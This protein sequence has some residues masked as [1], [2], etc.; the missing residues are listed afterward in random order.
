MHLINKLRS[1][2]YSTLYLIV[3]LAAIMLEHELAKNLFHTLLLVLF[4]LPFLN[5]SKAFTRPIKIYAGL[6][7]LFI[8]TTQLS[9]TL[10]PFSS[11]TVVPNS[12]LQWVLILPCAYLAYQ[13]K[14]N[15]K[16]L[17]KILAAIMIAT[18]IPAVH[19]VYYQSFRYDGMHSQP[20]MWGNLAILTG[21][22]AFYLALRAP[23]KHLW[24]YGLLLFLLGLIISAISQSRGGWISVFTLS[25]LILLELY[26]KLPK[27]FFISAAII[28]I[29]CICGALTSPKLGLGQRFMMGFEN[30]IKYSQGIK[31]AE[32]S[33]IGQRFEFWKSAIRASQEHP[34]F[35]IGPS[36]FK[37]WIRQDP[38]YRGDIRFNHAHSQYF[39]LLTFGIPSA[40]SFILMIAYFYWLTGINNKH[41]TT[42]K[43]CSLIMVVA[44]LEFSLTE[45]LWTS[46]LGSAYFIILSTY[47]LQSINNNRTG[48]RQP[49]VS[50]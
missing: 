2:K 1:T 7:F 39:D 31:N 17:F 27:K 14:A 49:E 21:F 13:S 11:R 33:S 22:L 4:A 50:N 19:D 34:V 48:N 6:A 20:I 8:L 29:V 10:S 36:G 18:I 42:I 43:Y 30:I 37:H 16:Q 26:K 23:S 40:I 46:Y 32:R 24:G 47:L 38:E 41:N 9:N 35:G 15:E 45:S 12:I 5:T 25:P 3:L 28:I 44:Y